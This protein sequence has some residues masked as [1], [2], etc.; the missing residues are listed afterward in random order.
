MERGY[1]KLW[2]KLLDS[3]LLANGPAWQLMGYLMLNATHKPYRKLVGGM[4]FDL[5]PGDV[6]IGRKRAADDLGLGEQ[7]IR[8]ALKL[9]EKLE[10]VTSKATNKCTVI[11]LINWGIYQAEQPATQP[12]EQPKANQQ[13]TS[14]QPTT[15][16]HLTT[17][18]EQK[19]KR[20]KEQENINTPPPPS[21]GDDAAS[22]AGL[23][24]SEEQAFVG[25]KYPADFSAFW[26]AYPNKKA[27][28]SALKAWQKRKKAK[29]LPSLDVLTGAIDRA[30]KSEQWQK[31]FIPYPATW[32]NAGSWQ[33]EEPQQGRPSYAGE[34][35]KSR[36]I[37]ESE[38]SFE[39][40]P[41][42]KD[43]F[44]DWSKV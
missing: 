14:T 23:P 41:M 22:A 43:G 11:S 26:Q 16:Q 13:L 19:N 12:A 32:L 39:N 21:Q 7:Q 3:G 20:T 25:T 6:V 27:K 34:N 44:L 40:L 9:L 37:R 36:Y 29:T 5:Q 15:N 1:V 28:D 2:R 17:R 4:A 42:T 10:I 38:Q 8:T 18:Q 30:K 31:G 24:E 33:D 35:G